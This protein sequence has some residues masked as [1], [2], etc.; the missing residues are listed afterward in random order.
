MF[1]IT[2]TLNHHMW[3]IFLFF[4]TRQSYWEL[5]QMRIEKSQS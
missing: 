3:T 5:A 4:K 1:S 2:Y